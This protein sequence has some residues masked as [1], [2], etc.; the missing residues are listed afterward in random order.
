MPAKAYR[1]DGFETCTVDGVEYTLVKGAYNRESCEGCIA[2]KDRNLCWG[3]APCG[4]KLV[5]IKK[6]TK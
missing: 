3:L 5:W 1:V 6:E 2:E 4:S